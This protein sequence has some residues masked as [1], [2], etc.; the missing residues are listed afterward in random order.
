MYFNQPQIIEW[1]TKK[2]QF[3]QTALKLKKKRKGKKKTLNTQG[4]MTCYTYGLV[5]KELKVVQ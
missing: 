2:S 1:I 5:G 4:T 3:I